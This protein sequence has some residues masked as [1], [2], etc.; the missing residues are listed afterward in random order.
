MFKNLCVINKLSYKNLN[1]SNSFNEQFGGDDNQQKMFKMLL[2][3]ID[4]NSNEFKSEMFNVM[5]VLSGIRPGMLYENYNDDP[6]HEN[7]INA[8]ID[9]VRKII[10]DHKLDVE[11]KKVFN[12]H[13]LI[14]LKKYK[15][16]AERA[17]NDSVEL[18]KILDFACPGEHN[19]KI[20]DSVVQR[21]YA[22][23]YPLQ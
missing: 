9:N 13:Y 1:S 8:V 6:K 5:T 15:D 23:D 20:N 3:S 16:L 22:Y 12:Q 14:Y 17:E 10:K 2:N 7:Q 21:I 11:I 4:D 18:G 19:D